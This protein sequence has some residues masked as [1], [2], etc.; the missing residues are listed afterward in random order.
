MLATFDLT[1]EMN[2]TTEFLKLT[3]SRAQT[4]HP[5]APRRAA[6]ANALLEVRMFN[7]GDGEAILVA[8][9]VISLYQ[10]SLMK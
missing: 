3:E 5:T 9:P 6:F 8:F 4:A 7:V 1:T 10:P 2:M